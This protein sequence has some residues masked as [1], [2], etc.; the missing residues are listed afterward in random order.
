H[1]NDIFGQEA[2]DTVLKRMEDDRGKFM[3]IAAGYEKEM[4]AFITSNP[5]LKS[6]FKEENIFNL[7]DYN[8]EELLGIYQIFAMK[9]GYSLDDVATQKL[10]KVL[11]EMHKHRDKN[12]GNGRAVRNLY[13][14]CL[15]RRAT[16]LQEAGD[17]EYDLILRAEDIPGEEDRK[18]LSVADAMAAL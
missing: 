7:P 15:A 4:Q 16:R 8:A 12:F 18:V 14:Q 10:Q 13:E 5:G 3:V 9:A 1:D 2:I 6:R 11:L 17:D